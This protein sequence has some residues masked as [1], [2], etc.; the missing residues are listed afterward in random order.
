[1]KEEDLDQ[2]GEEAEE[3]VTQDHQGG[4]DLDP[5]EG[6]KGQD[7]EDDQ[8]PEEGLAHDDLNFNLY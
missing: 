6:R 3:K 7:L 8:T 4:P 5:I 1:M 2:T